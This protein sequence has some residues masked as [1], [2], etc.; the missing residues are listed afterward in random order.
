M[1]FINNGFNNIQ[2]ELFNSCANVNTLYVKKITKPFK[3]NCK[4]F[5]CMCFGIL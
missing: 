5:S 4:I 2:N 1:Q 3:F